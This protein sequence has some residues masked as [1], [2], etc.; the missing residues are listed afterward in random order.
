M[1]ITR[2]GAQNSFRLKALTGLD[3]ESANQL[4]LHAVTRSCCTAA[5]PGTTGRITYLWHVVL[6]LYNSFVSRHEAATGGQIP[7]PIQ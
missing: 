1:S 5:N 3:R 4:Q 6:L 2:G 7:Y